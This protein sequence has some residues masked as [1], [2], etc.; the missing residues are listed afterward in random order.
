M[1]TFGLH[2]QMNYIIL[3]IKLP[4]YVRNLSDW[5]FH[6]EII[7]SDWSHNWLIIKIVSFLWSSSN[8]LR[9]LIKMMSNKNVINSIVWFMTIN[10]VVNFCFLWG[11]NPQT[12]DFFHFWFPFL[13]IGKII[14]FIDNPIKNYNIVTFQFINFFYFLLF[15]IIVNLTLRVFFN[16]IPSSSTY[17]FKLI[18]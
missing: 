3:L 8:I 12:F 7:L 13:E 11:K 16:F 1:I 18:E 5:L 14:Q 4:N 6:S 9:I 17:I 15:A 10:F 2:Y